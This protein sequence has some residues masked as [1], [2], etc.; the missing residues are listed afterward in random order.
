M[1]YFLKLLDKLLKEIND[2]INEKI[3]GI[4]YLEIIN[5]CL[6][7]NVQNLD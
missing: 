2:S 1:D 3:I 4:N 5:T 7:V 6:V